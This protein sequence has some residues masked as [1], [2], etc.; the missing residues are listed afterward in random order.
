MSYLNEFVCRALCADALEIYQI[1]KKGNNRSC[2]GILTDW[3]NKWTAFGGQGLSS[4]VFC[5]SETMHRKGRPFLFY[6]QHLH[7]I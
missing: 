2:K 3:N 1:S 4:F 7:A 5:I 6:F